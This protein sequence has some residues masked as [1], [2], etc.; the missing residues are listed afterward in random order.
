MD[1]IDATPIWSKLLIPLEAGLHY[2]G[3]RSTYILGLQ[4]AL[5]F[6]PATKTETRHGGQAV[7]F[8][9]TRLSFF[10]AQNVVNCWFFDIYI[11]GSKKYNFKS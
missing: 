8:V 7:I 4:I 9:G 6:V 3:V 2:F 1:M 5:N 10:C 11:Q